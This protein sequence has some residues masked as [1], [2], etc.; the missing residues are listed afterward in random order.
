MTTKESA[1]RRARKRALEST[2]R[3]TTLC[4][5]EQPDPACDCLACVRYYA[6]DAR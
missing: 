4:R 5:D 2:G 3:I 6:K 1:K